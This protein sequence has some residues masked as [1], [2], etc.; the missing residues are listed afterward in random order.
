[1][2][3]L[4]YL[5]NYEFYSSAMIE[6]RGLEPFK[7]ILKHLGGWPVIEGENWNENNFTW[8][9]SVY[10]C[11]EIGYSDSYFLNFGITPDVKNTTKLVIEVSNHLFN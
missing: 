6:Q 3:L 9:E 1:M 11:H 4:R 7:N 10:K 8:I 2:D 5:T